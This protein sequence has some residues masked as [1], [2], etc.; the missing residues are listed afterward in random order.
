MVSASEPG[1]I[2]DVLL[3][4]QLLDQK[5]SIF[6]GMVVYLKT[7]GRARKL[8]NIVS[9]IGVWN[10]WLL[11]SVFFLQMTFHLFAGREKSRRSH[12]PRDA[13]KTLRDRVTGMTAQAT[14]YLVLVY[15]VFLP[16]TPGTV[17]F[18][19]GLAVYLAGV[20]WL[21]WATLNFLSTPADQMIQ[22]GVYRMSRHPMYTATFLI[23][24]GTGT[25]TASWILPCLSL[26][27][28]AALNAEARREERYCLDRY[29]DA[30]RAYMKRVPRWIGRRR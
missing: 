16:L 27:M 28:L 24:L 2:R 7:A 26:V 6:T 14:W 20:V 5:P 18:S 29:G 22:K 13:V 9:R 30:Y 8:E 11:M 17:L 3:G 15:S 25:A 21:F 4:P 1:R 12:L 23:C 10:G 19:A